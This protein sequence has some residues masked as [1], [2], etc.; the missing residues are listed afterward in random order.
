MYFLIFEPTHAAIK[1]GATWQA[2]SLFVATPAAPSGRASRRHIDCPKQDGTEEDICQT[3]AVV[4][5]RYVDCYFAILKI[6]QPFR[7][8]KA[9][10]HSS[11]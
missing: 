4:G 10:Q 11:R 9:E 6:V 1:Q 7:P 3:V 2:V 5:D 8:Q